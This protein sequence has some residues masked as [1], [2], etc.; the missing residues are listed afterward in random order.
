MEHIARSETGI[1]LTRSYVCDGVPKV[2]DKIKVRIDIRCDRA[3]E[4][5]ELTDPRPAGVEPVSTRSGRR[6]SGGLGYYAVVGNEATQCFIDRL[7]KGRYTVE[8]EV[9]ATNPGQFLCAPVTVQC[10]YAPEF[11]A[12]SEAASLTVGRNEQLGDK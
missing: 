10:V 5:L 11:R 9:Y 3:M 2:G 6:F 7:E 12:H 1:T 8:Y 4:C